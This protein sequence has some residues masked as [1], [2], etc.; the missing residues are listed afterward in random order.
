MEPT[1]VIIKDTKEENGQLQLLGDTKFMFNI[2]ETARRWVLER[3]TGFISIKHGRGSRYNEKRLT[4]KIPRAKRTTIIKTN[5][6][7]TVTIL[8]TEGQYMR[9]TIMSYKQ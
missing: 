2:F 7:T 8:T 5:L 9:A 4:F 1:I 6:H 3:E